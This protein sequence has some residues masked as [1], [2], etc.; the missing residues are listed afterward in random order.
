MAAGKKAAAGFQRSS[1]TF[2]TVYSLVNPLPSLG[3]GNAKW[4]RRRCG[5]PL[6]PA[7]GPRSVLK[8]HSRSRVDQLQWPAARGGGAGRGVAPN[9]RP[10]LQ[11]SGSF[12]TGS[13]VPRLPS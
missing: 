5:E 6:N 13:R 2:P 7:P 12:E 1:S 9:R 10:T 3:V 11:V 8:M 4:L